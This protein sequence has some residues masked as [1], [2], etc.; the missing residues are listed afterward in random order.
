MSDERTREE[1][2]TEL[3]TKD[4]V[5]IIGSGNWYFFR[6]F[7]VIFQGFCAFYYPW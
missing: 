1:L 2:K 7:E 3:R 5:A 4:R 6:I